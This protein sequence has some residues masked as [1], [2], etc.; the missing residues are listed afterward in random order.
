MTRSRIELSMV[1][2][3][4]PALAKLIQSGIKEQDIINLAI[5]DIF[6]VKPRHMLLM[7]LGKFRTSVDPQL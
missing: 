7:T 5:M 6:W 1:Q 4:G 2:L 3:V